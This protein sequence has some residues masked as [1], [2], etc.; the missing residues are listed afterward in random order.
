MFE[1]FGKKE[2]K[3]ER[4]RESLGAKKTKE[5]IP[6]PEKFPDTKKVV[7]K[8]TVA[9]ALKMGKDLSVAN[10]VDVFFIQYSDSKDAEIKYFTERAILEVSQ[11]LSNYIKELI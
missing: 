7:V 8:G 4:E 9:Y 3:P 11:K 6:S 10:D 1:V 2:E 5:H